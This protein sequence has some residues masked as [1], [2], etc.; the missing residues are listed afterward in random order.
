MIKVAADAVQNLYSSFCFEASAIL[1]SKPSTIWNHDT[2]ARG[3][4]LCKNQIGQDQK[5]PSERKA[6]ANLRCG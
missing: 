3:G 6:V 4:L 2:P 1:H 5:E